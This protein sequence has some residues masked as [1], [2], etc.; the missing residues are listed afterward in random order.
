[1]GDDGFVIE[2]SGSP[3]PKS[4]Q[5]WWSQCEIAY[6]GFLR[7]G[8]IDKFRARLALIKQVE[9][10]QGGGAFPKLVTWFDD[11]TKCKMCG[12]REKDGIHDLNS[13]GVEGYHPFAKSINEVAYLYERMKGLVWVLM[14]KDC[15]DLPDKQYRTIFCRPT[16]EVMNT[17][18]AIMASSGT[19]ARALTL[20]RELSD[21]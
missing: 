14:K 1:W 17:M 3:A 4:P 20:L 12:L 21:G 10:F 5:D 13:M 6:P 15:L 9:A 18:R 8:R 19:G 7:E 2:M 11:E 16:T